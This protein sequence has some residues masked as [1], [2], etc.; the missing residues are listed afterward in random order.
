MSDSLLTHLAVAL[1]IAQVAAAAVMK[2]VKGVDVVPHVG[3][4]EDKPTEW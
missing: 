3:R 4:I 1:R 2:R